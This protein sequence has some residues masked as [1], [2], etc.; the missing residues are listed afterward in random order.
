ML[1]EV[2]TLR[3]WFRRLNMNETEP[4]LDERVMGTA[5]NARVSY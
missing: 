1:D 2:G 4:L 3:E 5:R